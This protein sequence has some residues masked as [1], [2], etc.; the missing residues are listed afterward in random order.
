[1]DAIE[2]QPAYLDVKGPGVSQ[3]VEVGYEPVTVGRHSQNM[4]VLNDHMSS[5]FHCLIGR[6]KGSFYVR[7]LNSSNGT[8]LNGRKMTSGTLDHGDVV[9]VGHT[10]IMLMIEGRP[11]VQR[12][13]EPAVPIQSRPSPGAPPPYGS[14]GAAAEGEEADDGPIPLAELES[15]ESEGLEALTEDDVAEPLTAEDVVADSSYDELPLVDDDAAD[16]RQTYISPKDPEAMLRRMAESLPNKSF[17][18][19]DIALLSARGQIVHQSGKQASNNEAVELFRLLLLVCSRSRATDIHLEPKNEGYLLRTRVDGVMVDLLRLSREQGV[20]FAALV[21]VLCELDLSQKNA[22]QEGHFSS[23]VPGSAG[24][25]RIDYRV[26]FAPLVFGQ[27][28]VMRILDTTYAPIH[29]AALGLPPWMRQEVEQATHQE[30]GMVLVCGPTGSGKTTTL[31]A[32]LRGADV[33]RR[34]VVTIEDPVEIQLA[35]VT[36]IP[37]NEEQGNSFSNLLRS[38]LR[39]D[40]DV[41]LIGEIRDGETARIA[42]QAAITGHLVFSTV[43]TRDTVGTIF[44][45]LDL[46]V[47]PYLVAQALHLVLSQRLA[48]QLCQFCKTPI[49]PT[50]HQLEKLGAVGHGLRKIYAA[51]GCP[52]CMGTGYSGRLAFFELLVASDELR[53]LIAR[54]PTLGQ[55]QDLLSGTPFQRL[56]Q[57]GY[58]LVAEGVVAFDEIDR[59]MGREGQ[60]GG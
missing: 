55:I 46:G 59:A 4:L 19:R 13:P 52:R 8:L 57:S 49:T 27:K 36:Q 31:Y 29:I 33:Q 35:A 60:L 32:L 18:E 56:H 40:P 26:S 50:A 44:R 43:H 37:V 58:H 41:I 39:Q 17:G 34:N 6:T 14:V 47:E 23:R 30:S 9:T 15:I 45:L 51:R 16:E 5:R 10:R 3:R 25:R 38:V 1:V 12:K 20:R 2:L 21:K 28:L 24:G 42:M 11:P 53:D 22:I 48:R 7:D 54:T